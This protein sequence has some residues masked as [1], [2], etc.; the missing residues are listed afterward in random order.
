MRTINSWKEMG[1][2]HPGQLL[3]HGSGNPKAGRLE[4]KQEGMAFQVGNPQ[5]HAQPPGNHRG[6]GRPEAP[7]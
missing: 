5:E 1:I 4:I 3:G 7:R 6:Q 2:P